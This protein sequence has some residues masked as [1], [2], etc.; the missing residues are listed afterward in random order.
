M[1]RI[2]PVSRLAS[3][4]ALAA[5]LLFGAAPS[6]LAMRQPDAWITTKVK[7]ALLTEQGVAATHIDVDTVDGLVTLHGRVASDAEAAHALDLARGVDGVR[8]VRSLLQVV[9]EAA[10]QQ[11]AVPDAELRTRVASALKADPA[12]ADSHVTVDSV[13]DGVVLLGGT[14]QTLGDH[15]RAIDDA[16]RVDGVRRVSSQIRSPDKLADDE[17]WHS[18][19][20]GSGEIAAAK[21]KITDLWI[22]SDAK[23]RLLASSDTPAYDINVDTRDGSVTLF[24]RVDSAQAKQKA[25]DEVRKVDGVRNVVND[26]QVVSP[27]TRERVARTDEALDK[28]IEDRLQARAG[29]AGSDVS[30]EVSGGVARLTGHV[31]SQSEH[32][33]VL[34]IARSTAGVTRVIDD[35]EVR[36]R[37]SA[38]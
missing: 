14:A 18:A 38:R 5:A 11:S 4:I 37:V 2:S 16:S 33:T 23:L 32:L 12:L 25:A 34:G 29:T 9:P 20:P 24:G 15:H 13:T 21:Q 1:R 19:K 7:I 35:V 3:R 10:K 36:S 27:A 30:V 8:D 28:S 31:D 26:L 22:T 6:A 17:L